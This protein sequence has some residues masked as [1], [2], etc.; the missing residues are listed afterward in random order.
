M[1]SIMI[2][3]EARYHLEIGSSARGHNPIF[4]LLFGPPQIFR[5]HP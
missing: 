2:E 5:S 1:N 3:F 4:L